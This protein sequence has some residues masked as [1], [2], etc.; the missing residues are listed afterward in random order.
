MRKLIF[1]LLIGSLLVWLYS[2]GQ[3]SEE[4]VGDGIFEYPTFSMPPP[5]PSAKALIPHDILMVRDSATTLHDIAGKLVQALDSARF[6]DR[7]FY[8]PEHEYEI[9]EG[10][11]LA[12]QWEQIDKEGNPLP[13][14]DRW[15]INVTPS[16]H[17]S[18][19]TIIK[20]LIGANT[21][22]FRVMVFFVMPNYIGQSDSVATRQ[23]ATSWTTEGA[24]FLPD[25]IGLE[26]FSSS[27]MQYNCTVYVY[28]F[29]QET[30]DDYPIQQKHNDGG[31]PARVHL[32]KSHLWT[33]LGVE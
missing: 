27:D 22:H 21:G 16:R 24:G 1:I 20:A 14:P 33:A 23:L 31:L 30:P 3:K 5:E 29:I 19:E 7:S 4:S 17:W 13:E 9:V 6:G 18:L 28:E 11:V 32:E 10:F 8:A 15:A 12:T 2:C 26:L 25:E